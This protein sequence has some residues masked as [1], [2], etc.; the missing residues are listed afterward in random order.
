MLL[1]GS[2]AWLVL[3]ALSGWLQGPW[4]GDGVLTSTWAG[5]SGPEVFAG[6]VRSVRNDG[7]TMPVDGVPAD[8]AAVRAGSAAGGSRSRPAC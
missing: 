2:A 1:A 8:S 6:R 4:V 3:L 7:I 5:G